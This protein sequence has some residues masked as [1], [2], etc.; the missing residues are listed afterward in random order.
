MKSETKIVAQ[1]RAWIESV[2]VGLNFCPFARR[3]LQRNSIRYQVVTQQ[4]SENCLQALVDELVLLDKNTAIETTLLIYPQVFVE[5]YEFLDFLEMANTLLKEQG[6]E[7]VFQLASFH[8]DYCFADALSDD[9]AN[10][11]NRSPYPMLHIIREASIE[12]ALRSYPQPEQIPE[13]NI[14]LARQK[15]VDVMQALRDSCMKD[16]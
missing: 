6:F 3:E 7:G 9:A 1:T 11:T 13:R 8:P 14:E 5:F 12:R 4:D 16:K 10:Y 2:I 15:G